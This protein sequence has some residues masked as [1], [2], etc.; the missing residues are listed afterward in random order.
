MR[1]SANSRVL[2]I[3]YGST[4]RGDDGVG[5]WVAD[6]IGQQ[7]RSQVEVASVTQLLPEYAGPVAHARA[8]IFV[9]A[10]CDDALE[11]T[12]VR[13]LTTSRPTPTS[14]SPSGWLAG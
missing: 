3:G 11:T 6:A 1:A 13:E 12:Q 4:L 2:V 14:G 8:V 10:S 5:R 9:D 7:R